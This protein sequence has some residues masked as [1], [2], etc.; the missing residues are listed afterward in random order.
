MTPAQ[1]FEQTWVEARTG[2]LRA[3]GGFLGALRMAEREAE[4]GTKTEADSCGMTTKKASATANTEILR[5]ALDD[6]EKALD[7]GEELARAG[8]GALRA[9]LEG[10]GW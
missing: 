7:D 2:A 9:E 6:G 8:M 4:A 10:W 1:R 3:R 5:F